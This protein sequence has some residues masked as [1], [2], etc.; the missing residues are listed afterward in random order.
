MF[1]GTL[2]WLE[3]MTR[4]LI[5][6][7]L[8]D[9]VFYVAHRL[10]HSVPSVYVA[11]HKLHH[12][13]THDVRLLSSLQMTAADV[14]LTHTLPVLAALAL[15]PLAPGLELSLAK[16]YLLFQELYGHAGVEHKGRC[17]G[18]APFLMRALGIEL[19]AA[20][21]RRHHIKAS[22]NFSKRLAL[23]DKLLGTWDSGRL[24]RQGQ[25]TEFQQLKDTVKKLERASREQLLLENESQ[26]AF[27]HFAAEIGRL[28]DAVGALSKVVDD[29]LSMV[30]NEV[31]ACRQEMQSFYAV[32]DATKKEIAD[33]NKLTTE[34]FA[35]RVSRLEEEVKSTSSRQLSVASD[36]A[37]LDATVE[38][39]ALA[40]VVTPMQRATEKMA[41]LTER[42]EVVENMGE[43]LI[44]RMDSSRDQLREQLIERM[45]SSRNQLREELIER[46]DSAR[47]QMRSDVREVSKEWQAKLVA[48]EAKAQEMGQLLR[49]DQRRAD[50]A[51]QELRLQV[52]GMRSHAVKLEREQVSAVGRLER[53]QAS[54]RE[55]LETRLV[56]AVE[57]TRRA[58][59]EESRKLERELAHKLTSVEGRTAGLATRAD[60][61]DKHVSEVEGR[62]ARLTTRADETD[63][64]V[65]EVEG[66]TARLTTRADETD[67]HSVDNL[68]REMQREDATLSE[69]LDALTEASRR[70]DEARSEALTAVERIVEEND[71]T[72]REAMTEALRD[73]LRQVDKRM[74]SLSQAHEQT[75]ERLTSQIGEAH[76]EVGET[77]REVEQLDGLMNERIQRNADQLKRLGEQMR[78]TQNELATLPELSTQA[79]ALK[80][81]CKETADLL[82]NHKTQLKKTIDG[83]DRRQE[84]TEY[85]ISTFAEAL[86]LPNPLLTAAA[87]V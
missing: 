33:S 68:S 51:T 76:Q 47:E 65:S 20:D 67:K 1:D 5:F 23:W 28:R 61:T 53:E 57:E 52:E 24:P 58:A 72:I 83:I 77:R 56:A 39:R 19:C 75:L 64:H 32:V 31:V 38:A 16:T 86:K 35:E 81:S 43:Q 41:K 8:F 15:V 70:N 22:V 74:Q 34:M 87:A 17:F 11:V 21:H 54:T 18:P 44:V 12:A 80:S 4:L 40:A 85:A 69:R 13:H 42:V 55:M 37:K 49:A 66:R 10:V 50:D 62:T 46:M 78:A 63:K 45:D 25:I 26:G 27:D 82:Q 29:E 60:E 14:A 6:E 36:V 73:A 59:E 7:V 9:G 30:R 2:W 48:A 71:S 84:V 79:R 3:L